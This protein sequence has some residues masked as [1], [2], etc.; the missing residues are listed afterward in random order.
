[1]SGT[2]ACRTIRPLEITFSGTTL[3]FL[4]ARKSRS[5]FPLEVSTKTFLRPSSKCPFLSALCP[6][7]NRIVT[8]TPFFSFPLLVEKPDVRLFTLR[9]YVFGTPSPLPLTTFSFF[10]ST[11][12][13]SMVL[14]AGRTMDEIF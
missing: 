13:E 9:T 10:L 1:M 8:S 5:E 6:F 12:Q 2:T 11:R 3:G 4:R 14:A 7:H